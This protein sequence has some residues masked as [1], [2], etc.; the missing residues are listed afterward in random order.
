M[1]GLFGN[2]GYDKG[3]APETGHLADSMPE[4][5]VEEPAEESEE[6]NGETNEDV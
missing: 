1:D 5:E 6:E 3:C 4:V 2:F